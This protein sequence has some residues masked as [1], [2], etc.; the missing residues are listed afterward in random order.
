MS[1][2]KLW[3][4][5]TIWTIIWLIVVGSFLILAAYLNHWPIVGLQSSPSA[6]IA[7]GSGSDDLVG[8]DLLAEAGRPAANQSGRSWLA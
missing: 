2:N 5:L 7:R 1:T 6:C 3:I 8:G 4:S